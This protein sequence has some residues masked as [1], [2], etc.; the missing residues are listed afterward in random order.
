M[1]AREADGALERLLDEHLQANGL[2]RRRI[3]KDGSCLFRAVA[4]QVLHCQGLHTKVRAA[5]VKYLRQERSSYESF[6]EG[7][8]E[9]YLQRLQDPQSWVGQVE[10][11]ALSVL[12]KHDFII[13]QE[14]GEPPVNITENGYPDKVRLCFLN[15]NHYD[16][17]Y[18]LSH[19]TNAAVC[20]SIL[21]ELLYERVFHVDRSVLAANMRSLKE[22][23]EAT[24]VENRSSDESD[25]DE[26]DDFWSSEVT[27]RTSSVNR[28]AN[29]K[30][31][32]RGQIRG[33]GR[34]HLPAKVLASLNHAYFRNVEYDVWLRS[35][36]AQQRRDF[37]M[38]AGMQYAAGDKCQVRVRNDG[39]YYSAYIQDVSPDD[40][41]VTVF[42][43]ELGEKH[44]VPLWNLRPPAEESWCTV[45]DK[46]KRHT[47]SNGNTPT[48]EWDTRGSR[49]SGHTVSSPHMTQA[50]AGSAPGNRVLKQHSWPPQASGEARQLGKNNS[51]RAH[52]LSKD[53]FRQQVMGD[54]MVCESRKTGEGVVVLTHE[55]EEEHALLEMLHK[56]ENN[57]PT[58][59]AS[60]Q[61]ACNEGSKRAERKGVRKKADTE[62]KEP[63]QR[64][65]QNSDR[66]SHGKRGT[67]DQDQRICRTL[68]GKPSPTPPCTPP[69]T[70]P[71]ATPPAPSAPKA[72]K[73]GPAL[74]AAAPT[75]VQTAP[76][77]SR[78][79][80]DPSTTAPTSIQTTPTQ[81]QTAPLVPKTTAPAQAQTAPF[82]PVTSTPAI[83]SLNTSTQTQ[84]A[85]RVNPDSTP[86]SSVTPD[87]PQ[88]AS[89]SPATATPAP[90]TTT[91]P[92]PS[93]P[94]SAPVTTTTT[95][96]L[97]PA[98]MP[99]T[100]SQ[101]P[102][103]T[104]PGHNPNTTPSPPSTT[105]PALAAPQSTPE[106]SSVPTHVAPQGPESSPVCSQTAPGPSPVI[107]PPTAPSHGPPT[108]PVE[109]PTQAPDLSPVLDTPPTAESVSAPTPPTYSTPPTVPTPAYA[110]H[111][112]TPPA[113][114]PCSVASF[115]PVGLGAFPSMQ[116]PYPPYPPPPVAGAMPTPP[117]VMPSA[118]TPPF[119]HPSEPRLYEHA[120]TFV[121]GVG[122]VAEYQ[123]PAP[124]PPHQHAFPVPHLLSHDPLYPGFPQNDK[125][126]AVLQ[127]PPFSLHHTGKDLPKDMNVLRWFFNLGVKAYSHPMWAPASYLTPLT[128]AYH[129][130]PKPLPTT[131]SLYTPQW[132]PDQSS[133]SLPHISPAPN[134]NPMGP[135]VGA[136]GGPVGHFEV[137]GVTPVAPPVE[138]G[139]Y[140]G[141]PHLVHMPMPPRPAV[142]WPA[143][144]TPHVF[145]GVYS[146][147]PP[148]SVPYSISIP[149][150]EA[151]PPTS[152][153]HQRLS[154]PPP[155]NRR[156]D[157]TTAVGPM[158]M[159]RGEGDGQRSMTPQTDK[160]TW[161]G[162]THLYPGGVDMKP[163][164]I[165][166]PTMELQHRGGPSPVLQPVPIGGAIGEGVEPTKL[167]NGNTKEADVTRRFRGGAS[168]EA[169]STHTTPSSVLDDWEAEE[170]E[171]GDPDLRSGRL[172]YSQSY[173]AG[174]RRGQEDRGGFRG[175][176]FRGRRDYSGRSRQYNQS[177]Y[178]RVYRGRGRGRGYTQHSNAREG[179]YPGGHFAP[180][181][182]T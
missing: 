27:V 165:P 116:S 162:A 104:T 46:G 147:P 99:H 173:K 80:L 119:S 141:H 164:P 159:E 8:F 169:V 58:L 114:I 178:H 84:T 68:G 65:S 2:Y 61:A 9:E 48:N 89:L 101:P 59:G 17:V 120:P 182:E 71:S 130:Q 146:L 171:Y 107:V 73:P 63:S 51:G 85:R 79:T 91:V 108:V 137:R 77:R 150:G 97:S 56:D 136:G 50:T 138:V 1:E 31:R 115:H 86:S 102:P 41:P 38:A 40:G 111:C 172:Y 90:Q 57:F 106:Y 18:P 15:G 160:P 55:E 176:G 16:S 76:A 12:Y 179:G 167:A 4:E 110:S 74:P 95:T 39:R 134:Y 140:G 69:S 32:G 121:S 14:P 163:V 75:S 170:A 5:C 100:V 103:L 43:E 11:T 145:P 113:T 148:G 44:T 166:F 35:K 37:C 132:H 135:P 20:Q 118:Q 81:P 142:P 122:P 126:D 6:I 72:T 25:L 156:V 158:V 33:G 105:S 52:W 143:A 47:V 70:T 26:G 22:S 125:D 175:G 117:P 30:G 155:L 82:S 19:T 64:P 62:M 60:A 139:G 96:P 180:S 93:L 53:G 153:G 152:M 87:P 21:Y 109:T 45:T 24:E 88:T 123:T 78:T 168:G 54:V 3:A 7:D 112:V 144:H 98:V 127:P 10:I 151:Y 161:T 128:Q 23:D 49:K 13:Y 42:I 83:V 67:V 36:K 181:P 124:A 149:G 34:G 28:R 174:G 154:I 129:M 177:V 92:I 131:S 133:A 29:Y 94:P 66:G 157:I